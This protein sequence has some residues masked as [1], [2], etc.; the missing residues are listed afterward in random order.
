ML[1]ILPPSDTPVKERNAVEVP[2]K[3]LCYSV[4]R[5][6]AVP[7]L[8]SSPFFSRTCSRGSLPWFPQAVGYGAV[9]LVPIVNAWLGL[10]VDDL[11]IAT[12]P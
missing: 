3:F 9:W 8:I 12:N 4:R 1:A 2:S 11:G 5:P 7:N 6:S 10:T